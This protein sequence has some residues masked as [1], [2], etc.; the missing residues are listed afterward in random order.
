M[1]LALSGTELGPG[2]GV[3]PLLQ[4]CRELAVEVVELWYPQNT[5]PSGVE[6]TVAALAAAG[7]RVGCIGTATELG[8]DGD[9]SA[10]QRTVSE[11]VVLAARHGAEL[12]NTYFGW[13]EERDDEQ[14]IRRYVRNV[15]PCLELATRHGVTITLENEFDA[16]T[17]DP[18]GT[19][20]TRRPAALAQ[21]LATVDSDRFRIAFDPC[22]ALFA[23]LDPLAMFSVIER[24]VV[25]VHLKDGVA[26]D[27][28]EDAL[29]GWRRFTDHGRHWSTTAMGIGQVGWERL[30]TALKQRGFDG[31]LALE[32]H[33][34]RAELRTAWRQ[35][36]GYAR[37]AGGAR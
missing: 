1:R 6:A 15:A 5:A 30:F 31:L 26:V 32:P 35:A 22:N 9:V 3:G 27:A 10:A 18:L 7:V 29:P 14:A 16:F 25:Y 24:W 33:G 11:A 19:D 37:L 28:D 4:A 20:L 8:G 17:R 21:L 23:G 12:V 2:D 36:A 13:P 34:Q